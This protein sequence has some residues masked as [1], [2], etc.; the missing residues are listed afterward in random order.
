MAMAERPPSFNTTG[1]VYSHYKMT[2]SEQ[3]RWIATGEA[4]GDGLIAA[5]CGL[6]ALWRRVLAYSPGRRGESGRRVATAD[7]PAEG[8]ST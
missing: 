5:A 6:A 7:T 2:T 8:A 1:Q 3:R 4:I